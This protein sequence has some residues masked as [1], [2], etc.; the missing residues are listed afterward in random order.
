MT[1]RHRWWLPAEMARGWPRT[2]L[3]FAGRNADEHGG[4]RGSST[5]RRP[6]KAL[7]QTGVRAKRGIHDTWGQDYAP[8]L[9]G[10]RFLINRRA[11]DGMTEPV[12]IISPWV[13]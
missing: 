10:Q 5:E 8:G 4:E 13:P 3:S 9:D 6:A 2:I 11:G 1:N 7:F 12:N